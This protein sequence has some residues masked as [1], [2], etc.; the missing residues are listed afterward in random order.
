MGSRAC[1]IGPGKEE[2]AGFGFVTLVEE[3]AARACAATR[4]HELHGKL[5][6]VKEYEKREARI[7]QYAR[8]ARTSAVTAQESNCALDAI[9]AVSQSPTFRRELGDGAEAAAGQSNALRYLGGRCP[10]ERRGL[11]RGRGRGG[12]HA[13][14]GASRG[15]RERAG[16]GGARPDLAKVL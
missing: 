3:S 14:R 2:N 9:I 15:W 13:P 7:E 8:A 6:D 5:I 16:D 1:A 10:R 12:R 4:H 11:G